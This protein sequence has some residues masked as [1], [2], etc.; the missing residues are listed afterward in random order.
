MLVTWTQGIYLFVSVGMT[1]YVA[2][3]LKTNGRVFLL[4][5]FE[6]DESITDSVNS[7]L[8]VGFY[9]LNF[10]WVLLWTK[11][12]VKPDSIETSIE[13]VTTKVG[14]VMLI[15]G[16]LHFLNIRLFWKIQ[17]GKYPGLRVNKS[18]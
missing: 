9:L 18:L 10:G 1:I 15:L 2:W 4:R 3:S 7:L 14:V 5:T 17:Q 13:F 16:F 12:G 8:V 11:Y 6:G